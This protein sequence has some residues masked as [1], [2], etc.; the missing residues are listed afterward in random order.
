MLGITSHSE[1]TER[2]KIET[3]MPP[4]LQKVS[5]CSIPNWELK[6]L[7]YLSLPHDASWTKGDKRT[8]ASHML[9][10]KPLIKLSLGVCLF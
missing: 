5:L 2:M 6:A 7:M 10:T 9:I 4:Q 3:V 1:F 8:W